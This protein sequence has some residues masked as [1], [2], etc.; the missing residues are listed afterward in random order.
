MGSISIVISFGSNILN[1]SEASKHWSLLIFLAVT[2]LKAW[3]KSADGQT[4]PLFSTNY[5]W[6]SYPYYIL[7]SY[8]PGT[9]RFKGINQ[10][11]I[12]YK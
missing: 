3:K 10:Y 8:Y 11:L 7:L 5:C 9:K 12:Q 4:S 1:Q 6:S 2:P